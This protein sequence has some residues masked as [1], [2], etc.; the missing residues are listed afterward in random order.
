[1]K[2]VEKRDNGCAVCGMGVG[3]NESKSAKYNQKEYP[4]CCD[5]CLK[6][7]REHPERYI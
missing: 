6:T 2:D 5:N 7:F 3:K 1:M 4:L